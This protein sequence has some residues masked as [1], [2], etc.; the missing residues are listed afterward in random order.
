MNG[1]ITRTVLLSLAA[2]VALLPSTPAQEGAADMPETSRRELAL[3]DAMQQLQEARTAY[4]EQKYSD[5]VEHYR[6]ALAVLPQ[7]PATQK[8]QQFIRASLSDALI[9]KAMD[10]RSVGRLDEAI[11]F[12]SEAIELDPTNKRARQ[13]L[14]RTQ[15]PVRNNPALTPQHIGNVESVNR[16]LT[17]GYGHLDLGKYDD[18]VEAFRRALQIDPYNTAAQRGIETATKRKQA[19]YNAAHDSARAAALAQVDATW[20]EQVPSDETP[21]AAA[22]AETAGS[23]AEDSEEEQ[24]MGE[25]LRTIT[26][27][28]IVFDDVPIMDVV[29]ALQAQINSHESSGSIPASRHIN[30]TTNFGSPDSAGYTDIM[31]RRVN[32]KLSDVT[33]S[34]VLDALAKQLGITYHITATGVQLSYSGKDFGPMV[35]RSYT[36]APHFFDTETESDDDEDSDFSSST[37]RVR[38]VNPV[39]ALKGMG[40]SFPEGATARYDAASRTLTVRNTPYNQEEIAELTQ[41]PMED[42]NQSVVLNIIAMEVGEKDLEELGFEWLVNLNLG[43]DFLYGGGGVIKTAAEAG[44]VTAQGDQ[45]TQYADTPSASMTEGLR[46]GAISAGSLERLIESG[47]AMAYAQN[48]MSS[49]KAPGIFSMRG[50]WNAGDVTMIMRGLSQK[51]ATDVLFSPRFVF[52][53][54][55][56]QQVSFANVRELFYPESYSEPQVPQN[57]SVDGCVVAPAHP[58]EFTRFGMTE[59]DVVG[60]I[61]SIVQVH[62]AQASPDGNVVTVALT[63][64]INEFEGFINWGSP[65]TTA[66]TTPS[67][68]VGIEVVRLSENRILKPLFKR[69]MENTKVSVSPGS[70]LVLGGLQEAQNVRFEDKL[71]VL[72]DLPLVGRLFR[73]EGTQTSR[74]AFLVF[75]KIDLVD[76]TGKDPHTGKRPANEIGSL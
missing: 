73:S 56:E 41:I 58:E 63:F 2:S 33:L 27:A 70:V 14:S 22:S 50:I 29:D 53:P 38:R 3:R 32:L 16:E 21:V 13:E 43:P 11:E 66:I 71:P 44:W 34:D 6:N 64:T 1:S 4:S 12:L 54:G 31:A 19:Y 49:A 61:G 7:A 28:Q 5:A 67:G 37:I 35:E 39:Q 18:A 17:L 10:Y 48:S 47:S 52:T 36:V 57:T 65:I 68:N 69:R 62:S 25:A 26:L 60:G 23:P 75:I 9:A 24:R 72:G 45:S 40:I 55:A 76:P 15:D 51:K 20:E 42:R 30:L 59:E 8:Q 74:K 46:S